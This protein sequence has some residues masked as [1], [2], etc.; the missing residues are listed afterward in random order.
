MRLY[1]SA[2]AKDPKE[3]VNRGSMNGVT[4]TTEDFNRAKEQWG[5]AQRDLRLLEE[6]ARAR[7]ADQKRQREEL[8]RDSD[9]ARPD[10]GDESAF[11]RNARLSIRDW[12]TKL[13]STGSIGPRGAGSLSAE[14]S[15]GR[16]SNNNRDG[17]PTFI[18][19]V[20]R[21]VRSHA[22]NGRRNRR[23]RTGGALGPSCE[24]ASRCS[25]HQSN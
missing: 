19:Q 25:R 7:E 14:F 21:P 15:A 1:E 24:T 4:L 8:T 5:M 10:T 20:S 3:E 17:P 11:R 23:G 9:P 22:P 12:R 6:L 2:R 13:G 16:K 18:S